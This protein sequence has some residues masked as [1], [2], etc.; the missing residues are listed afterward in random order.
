MNPVT[1]QRFNNFIFLTHGYKSPQ[2]T[3]QL[4]GKYL[5]P[6]SD[7]TTSFGYSVLAASAVE[8]IMNSKIKLAKKISK[9]NFDLDFN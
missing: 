1:V 9:Y 3:F 7:L 8:S 4:M 2:R 6:V 5:Q